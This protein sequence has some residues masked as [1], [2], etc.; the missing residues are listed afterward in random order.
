MEDDLEHG[1]LYFVWFV[2]FLNRMA[3]QLKITQAKMA[4]LMKGGFL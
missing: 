3:L 2:I 4:T 1:C